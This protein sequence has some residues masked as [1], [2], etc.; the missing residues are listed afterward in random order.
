MFPFQD[1]LDERIWTGGSNMAGQL[2]WTDT[3]TP[4]DKFTFWRQGEPYVMSDKEVYCIMKME[5]DWYSDRCTHNRNFVC[6]KR[7]AI[8]FTTF[9]SPILK[10]CGS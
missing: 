1:S 5:D 8:K 3:Q 9:K 4:V 6:E 7:C 10:L 2:T